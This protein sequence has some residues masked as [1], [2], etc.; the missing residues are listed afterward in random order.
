MDEIT[1]IPPDD[2]MAELGSF[3]D[4]LAASVP[5]KRLEDNLLI[6]TWNIK[7]FGGLDQTWETKPTNSP[8]RNL[9]ALRFIA[10][11]VSQFDVIA[12]QEVRGTLKSLRHLM[13]ALG[14]DWAF[15]LTDVN[16]GTAGNDERM[17]FVFDTRR[18]RPSGLACEL[19]V[20]PEWRQEVGEN[21]LR[22]Q[23][24]RSPYAVSFY[25]AGQTFIVV[26]LHVLYGEA[27]ADRIPELR[28]IAKW[29]AGWAEQEE[30]WRHN[31]LVLGDFNTENAG[32]PT[33]E[34]LTSTGLHVP[35]EIRDLSNTNLPGADLPKHYDQ[36]SWFLG[37]ESGSRLTLKYAGHA[38]M[39]DFTKAVFRELNNADLQWRMSDHLPLWVEFGIPRA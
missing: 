2:V 23:F 18:V 8:K 19:V 34:A 32:D 29:M 11:I 21:V 25:S 28:G 16:Q 7:Q 26:T 17:A 38:G 22:E 13:K 14:P 12:L 15:L 6:A 27:P 20:P 30:E 4:L 31:L 3:Q 35:L 10:E 36:I 37:G 9:R 39:V 33:Y 24:A 5:R 1:D